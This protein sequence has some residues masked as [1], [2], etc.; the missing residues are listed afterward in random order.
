L[1]ALLVIG[2]LIVGSQ[3]IPSINAEKVLHDV[4]HTLGGA[5]YVLAGLAAFL[6][7]GA[8]VGL[9]LPG[10]TVVILAGAVAGQGATSIEATIAVVWIGAFGGDSTSFWIGRRLGRGFA[11]RH[12]AKLRITEER[13]ERVEAYFERYGGRTI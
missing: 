10:E 8:F 4:S 12:G 11:L 9:I 6:E 5:T 1:F 13:L 3:L 7:T 2:A